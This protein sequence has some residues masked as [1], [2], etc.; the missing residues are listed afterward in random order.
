MST[1]PQPDEGVVKSSVPLKGSSPNALGAGLLATDRGQP[2]ALQSI[3]PAEV[4]GR[5]NA[6]G[7]STPT[8]AATVGGLLHSTQRFRFHRYIFIHVSY[9]ISPSGR[10]YNRSSLAPYNPNPV[11]FPLNLGNS[12]RSRILSW[13]SCP[14]DRARPPLLLRAGKRTLRTRA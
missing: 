6:T 7:G 4:I 10:E 1:I 2:P 8:K 5:F 14:R 13:R 11:T 3:F 9:C 12:G